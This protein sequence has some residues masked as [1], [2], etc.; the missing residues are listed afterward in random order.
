M[1]S[2]Y[3]QYTQKQ[4]TEY[5]KRLYHKKPK[6]TRTVQQKIDFK[7]LERDINTLYN[8][9]YYT[10]IIKQIPDKDKMVPKIIDTFKD[11]DIVKEIYYN[12]DTE[13]DDEIQL[14]IVYEHDSYG[15]ATDTIYN[16][17]N[18]LQD[19]FP[20]VRINGLTFADK[21]SSHYN[22]SIIFQRIT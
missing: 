18:K 9:D 8:S 22:S 19:Q 2:Q 15:H 7:Q 14:L 16:Q 3:Q 11:T 12:N 17:L 13:C 20:D 6:P 4:R 21:V 1:R 5:Y 10:W